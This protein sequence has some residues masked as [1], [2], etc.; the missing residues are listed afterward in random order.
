MAFS[1]KGL[2]D[3]IP[4]IGPIVSSVTGY[5]AQRD[6]NKVANQMAQDQRSWEE[7]MSN[8]AYQR[9]IADMRQAGL[10]PALAYQQGGASTPT[11][12]MGDTQE[13]PMQAIA[14]SAKEITRMKLEADRM[15]QEIATAKSVENKNNADAAVMLEGLPYIKL[16]NQIPNFINSWVPYVSPKHWKPSDGFL[17]SKKKSDNTD[18]AAER[19]A[20]R[21]KKWFSEPAQTGIPRR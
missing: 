15:K 11:G 7:Q 13:S 21:I 3:K 16:R 14:S 6:Q 9:A 5:A 1:L 8:S 20:D 12:A 2:V 10:N 19:L 17:K 4:V 18:S